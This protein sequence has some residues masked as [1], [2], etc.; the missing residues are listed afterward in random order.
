MWMGNEVEFVGSLGEQDKG[1][2]M[3]FEAGAMIYRSEQE[4]KRIQQWGHHCEW[5]PQWV[6]IP[7]DIQGFVEQVPSEKEEIYQR[8]FQRKVKEA[9]E[10]LHGIDTEDL[11]LEELME[12]SREHWFWIWDNGD[13]APPRP[14]WMGE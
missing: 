12:L 5:P 8:V 6:R 7:L 9:L 1:G 2:C 14:L 10:C 4:E 11:S 3:P 13:V